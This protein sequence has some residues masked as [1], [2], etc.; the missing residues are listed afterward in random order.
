MKLR[1]AKNVWRRHEHGRM[2]KL[3]TVI[4]AHYTWWRMRERHNDD[5][6]EFSII[7]RRPSK[8]ELARVRRRLRENG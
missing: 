8:R 4:D 3:R 1:V 6:D 7:K 5:C 2:Y